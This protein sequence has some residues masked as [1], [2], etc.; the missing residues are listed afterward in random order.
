MQKGQAYFGKNGPEKNSLMKDTA[1]IILAAGRGARM[2]SSLP[3]VLHKIGGRT[4]IERALLL[5]KPFSFKPLIVVTG[6]KGEEVARFC[7][8]AEVVT[9]KSL[10]GSADA[11]L[12]AR[13]ALS[14]FKGNVVVLYADVPL[15]KQPTIRELAET[16]KESGAFCTFLTVKMKNPAGYGRVLRDDNDN[17][18]RIVEEREA[19]LYDK[20]IEE[21]NAGVYCFKA[22]QLFDSLK[23]I[24]NDNKKG[25][26]YLT[27]IISVF[28]KKNLKVECVQASDEDE[29]YGINSRRELAGA[30]RIL[31]LRAVEKFMAEGVGIIDPRNTRI[32]ISCEIG[33]DT[34]IMPFTI[35]EEGV[36]IGSNCVIGPFARLRK[37][38][39]LSDK[40]EIGNFVELTRCN[41][42]M[43][44]K[45]KHHTYI[46]DAVI[47]KNV[48]IGAGAITANYDGKTKQKTVIKEGA[49]IG[50]GTIFVAPVIVGKKAVTGAGSVL[51]KNTTVP[52][53]ALVAGV[54]ARPLKRRK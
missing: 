39:V 4:M 32:D 12:S 29:A 9:Q 13:G 45:I 52:D 36:T 20:A 1:C 28:R 33:Q 27:D 46:G 25:E 18:A 3:K 51:T 53:K 34:V 47:G 35:I 24:K 49:F 37:G 10:L 43:G 50:S 40:V 48:N 41:I 31:N 17:I 42:G 21:V 44:A 26:Y 7:G 6:Y 23:E 16:H 11:V 5:V 38:T 14:K 54:P 15:V 30:E 2:K 19:S 22:Q 8:D